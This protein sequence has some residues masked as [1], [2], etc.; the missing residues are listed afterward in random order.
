MADE[1]ADKQ[2]ALM[3][4]ADDWATIARGTAKYEI[5]GDFARSIIASW[6]HCAGHAGTGQVD[7]QL[8]LWGVID[9]MLYQFGQSA[10]RVIAEARQ[11][12]YD[13]GTGRPTPT[14]RPARF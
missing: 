10:R 7:A 6:R 11:H 8:Y 4:H 2:P 3:I 9:G 12:S 1:P 5:R 14:G 13:A